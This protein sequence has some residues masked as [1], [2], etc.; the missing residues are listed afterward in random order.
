MKLSLSIA[1]YVLLVVRLPLAQEPTFRSES[2][3]VLVPA[4]VKDRSGGLVYGLKAKDFI[5]EDDGVAQVVRLDDTVESEPVS[6]VVAIQVGR[7]ASREFPRV[8]GLGAMLDPLLERGDSKA[9]LVEFDSAV[10]LM[11]TFTNDSELIRHDLQNLHEGDGGAA[12]LDAIQY[13][14]QLLRSTPRS[15]R[16]VLLLI[17]ETR[18]HGSKIARLDDVVA[19][20]G[21]S[22]AVI[23]AL[24]FSPSWS[25]VLD[26]E[27]GSNRDEWGNQPD[28]LAPILMARQSLRRN[29]PKAVATMTGGEYQLFASLK[30]FER[31]MT[32][33]TNHV[34]ARY[35]LSF[36]PEDPRPGL[37]HIR[38][39][40]VEGKGGTVQARSTYWAVGTAH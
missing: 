11:R 40:L 7:R 26:T 31:L 1:A 23:C 32:D 6:L 4:L 27:R 14:I 17:S 19:S 33:F 10:R 20:V 38:V 15:H 12:I 28:L 21:D 9:A 18:D 16:R 35:V 39:R 25:Q 5:V 22:S 34:Q 13:S 37:H 24:T 30:E 3:V 36:Q 8:R 2:N 29:T